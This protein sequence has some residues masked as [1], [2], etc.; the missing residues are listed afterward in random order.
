MLLSS[1]V[2]VGQYQELKTCINEQIVNYDIY[3]IDYSFLD[4]DMFDSIQKF[5]NYLIE[6]KLL[7]KKNYKSYHKFINSDFEEEDIRTILFKFPFL[8][9]INEESQN[10]IGMYNNCPSII[11]RNNMVWS[12]TLW[13]QKKVYDRIVAEGSVNSE[14][15]NELSEVTDYNNYVSRLM[16]CNLI[17]IDWVWKN[18]EEIKTHFRQ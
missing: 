15:L 12:E 5:E 8:L 4:F 2:V 16:L 6:K 10:A 18:H 17:F 3:D 14:I 9:D 13:P 11:V 7:N 1:H